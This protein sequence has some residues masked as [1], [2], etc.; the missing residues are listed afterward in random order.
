M[1]FVCICKNVDGIPIDIP[2]EQIADVFVFAGDAPIVCGTN[3]S[4]EF[5]FFIPLVFLRD[6]PGDIFFRG[7]EG[8]VDFVVEFTDALVNRD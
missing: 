6:E 7:I 4:F 5:V 2:E 8:S 1:V 3:F